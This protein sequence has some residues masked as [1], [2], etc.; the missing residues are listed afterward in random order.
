MAMTVVGIFDDMTHAHAAVDA[1]LSA[2]YD[3]DHISVMRR[4]DDGTA[5][6]PGTARSAMADRMDPDAAARRTGVTPDFG[7]A[8]AGAADSAATLSAIDADPE[9]DD[10]SDILVSGDKLG[11]GTG[12]AAGAGTGAVIGGTIGVL[13]GAAGFFIPGLGAVLGMGPMLATILGG[14][15]IGAVAGGLTG[16]LTNAGVPD[17]DAGHYAEGV[18]RGGTLVTVVAADDTA[19]GRAADLLDDAGAYDVNE[20]AATWTEAAAPTGGN[21]DTTFISTLPGSSLTADRPVAAE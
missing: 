8:G 5:P 17:V 20:R 6:T 19:A 16:A 9:N 14:A 7:M 4:Q 11:A 2:G 3:R 12:A 15:G 18:R 10:A 21:H 1:L 13:T